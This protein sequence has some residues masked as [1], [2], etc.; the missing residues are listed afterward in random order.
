METLSK[1]PANYI[2]PKPAQL[3]WQIRA[4]SRQLFPDAVFS[5]FLKM[6]CFSVCVTQKGEVSVDRTNKKTEGPGR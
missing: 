4:L 5:R 3:G 6:W 2:R 1:F